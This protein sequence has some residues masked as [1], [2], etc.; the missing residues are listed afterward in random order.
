MPF[1]GK[2]GDTFLMDDPGGRHRYVILTKPNNDRVVMT[3]WTTAKHH[4]W[5]VVF[6]PKHNHNLF[7]KRCTPNYHD[8]AFYS[9]PRIKQRTIS[10]YAFCPEDLLRK[11]IIG[12]FSSQHTP[13]GVLEELKSQYLSLAAEYY[14]S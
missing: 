11:V 13:I 5:Q 1:T 3:N 9:L 12:A 6:L 4:D 7:T 8:I 10:D 14:I 2:V